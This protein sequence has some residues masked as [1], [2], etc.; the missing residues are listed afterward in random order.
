M[1]QLCTPQLGAENMPKALSR[2]LVLGSMAGFG[3]IGATTAP[4]VR[5]GTP[6]VALG[7]FYPLERR[8]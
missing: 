3:L 5:R 8:R 1:A 6:I 4:L 7:P 2:R